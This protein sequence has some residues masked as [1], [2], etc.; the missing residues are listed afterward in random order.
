D[1]ALRYCGA[2]QQ[3]QKQSALH[4]ELR[5]NNVIVIDTPASQMHITLVDEYMALKR[6]GVF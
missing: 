6:S 1:E 4:S 3:I 2:S 5:G